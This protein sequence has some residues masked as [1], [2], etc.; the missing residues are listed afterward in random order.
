MRAH[1]ALQKEKIPAPVRQLL[2]ALRQA[3]YKAYPVGGCVRDLLRGVPPHDWDITTSAAPEQA[4]AALTGWRVIETGIKHGTVTVLAGEY[5]VEL[6]TF[7]GEGGYTDGR[8]PD[9]VTFGV[10]PEEDLAR[11]DFTIGAMAWDTEN[12][13]L[14]DPYGGQRDLENGLL[15]AVGDPDRR[16]AEDALRILRGLRFAATLGFAIEPETAAA[17]RRNADR[18]RELSAERVRGELQKLLCGEA[19]VPVLRDYV[20]VIGVVLPELLPMVGFGQNNPHHCKDVWEHTLTVLQNVPPEP[21]LRWT[22]L[23]HDVEKPACCTVDEAGIRHFKGHQEKG[24]QTA[25]R[26]LRR[27]HCETRFITDVTELIRI[28]DIRFP[29]TVEMATRWAGR[30]G[31]RRFLQF[32]ALRRADTLGQAHP[33]EA[34]PYYLAMKEAYDEAKRRNAC[35]TVRQLAVSGDDLTGLGLS[36]PAVGEALRQLLRAVQSGA[37]PN[38]RNALLAAARQQE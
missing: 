2:A 21:E 35:F 12:D 31:E 18:L 16:F 30:W 4:E 7:R 1:K 37:L 17:L 10:T 6:T 25:E 15:R 19:A 38:E 32:L 29:A 34:E 26:I 23:L 3:G 28:H 33:E 5:P 20:G 11:R 9:A 27:L 24:A 13:R 14:L 36:G 8:H 22:A